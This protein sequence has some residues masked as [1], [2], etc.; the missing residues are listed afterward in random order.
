MPE[1]KKLLRSADDLRQFNEADL[2]AHNVGR[3]L[4]IISALKYPELAYQRLLRRTERALNAKGFIA[5][6]AG[7]YYRL[8][9]ARSSQRLGVSIPPNVFGPGL[10]IAHYGSIVVTDRAKVG[11]YC[12]IHS[13]TNIGETKDGAP[14]LG[15]YVYVG[16]GAVIYGPVKIGDGAVIA[17]NSVVGKNVEAGSVVAGAPARPIGAGGSASVM[18]KWFPTSDSW[19][20][21][22]QGEETNE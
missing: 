2:A 15:D 5:R 11:S 12:R 9:L 4:P 22:S 20:V 19:F 21:T 6:S 3:W 16:P 1:E 17:A 10:S 18:P 8:R 14:V 13:A 7:L